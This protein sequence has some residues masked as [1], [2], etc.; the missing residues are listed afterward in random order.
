MTVPINVDVRV[1][2]SVLTP[3]RQSGARSIEHA[4]ATYL[5]PA[6]MPM[7]WLSRRS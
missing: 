6:A 1:W 3:A 4:R 2:F 5:C 7:R